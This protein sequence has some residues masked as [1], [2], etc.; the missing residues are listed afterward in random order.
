AGHRVRQPL[1]EL[2]FSASAEQADG[3]ERLSDVIREELNVKSLVRAEHLDELVSYTYK[4]NLKTLGPKHGKR[5][6]AI[7]NELPALGDEQ[8]APLRRGENVTV[9]IGG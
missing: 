2:R 7:R 3:I 5:L 6:A 9:V 1:A 8:L 4:P